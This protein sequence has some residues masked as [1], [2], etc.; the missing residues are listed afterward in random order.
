MPNNKKIK[1]INSTTYTNLSG[2]NKAKSKY[3]NN[4]NITTSNICSGIDVFEISERIIFS[5]NS[6]LF[7]N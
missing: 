3:I 7:Q 1:I 5:I 2:R 4:K 6:S